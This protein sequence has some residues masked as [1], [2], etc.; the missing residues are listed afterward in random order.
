MNR[1][2]AVDPFTGDEVS[3][4]PDAQLDPTVRLGYRTGRSIAERR[5]I[6]GAGAVLRSGTVI[7]EGTTIGEYLETGHNVVIREQ[8]RLGD[9]VAIWN[10]TVIDYGCVLGDRVHLHCN[11]YVAQFSILEDDVFMAP[12]VTIAND[13]HPGCPQSRECMRG[14]TL[15][16]GVKIGVNV[17]ILPFVE[18]GEN[19]LIGSGAVVTRDI[20]AFAVAYGNPARVHGDVR[21]LE[22]VRGHRDR[23]YLFGIVE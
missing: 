20:P 3:L 10:N 12:G 2:D 1:R 17:T 4:G 23:P 13:I 6:I 22:C 8:N 14:P 7:Y 11:I 9:K 15:R 5:L 16:K 19:A 21:E 18:I